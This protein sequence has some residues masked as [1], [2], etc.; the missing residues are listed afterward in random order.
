MCK[1]RTI[2]NIINGLKNYIRSIPKHGFPNLYYVTY[3]MYTETLTRDKITHEERIVMNL[4][5]RLRYY[6]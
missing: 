4:S 3:C 5:D 6:K 2:I 1:N